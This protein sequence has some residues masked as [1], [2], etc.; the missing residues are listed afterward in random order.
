MVEETMLKKHFIKM[1]G[2]G[3]IALIMAIVMCFVTHSLSMLLFG[4]LV[5]AYIGATAASLWIDSKKGKVFSVYAICTGKE[6]LA[7]KA[8]TDFK[9]SIEY[10]FL[11][12]SDDDGEAVLYL[13]STNPLNYKEGLT[14]C[15]LFRETDDGELSIRNLIGSKEIN[16]NIKTFTV[17]AAQEEFT[18]D[19]E[20]EMA[21]EITP[22]PKITILDF[23]DAGKEE[24]IDIGDDF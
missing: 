8:S 15:L 18:E 20:G 1:A 10:Q 2:A 22:S 24:P 3:V 5:L 21:L 11:V 23:A 16:P 9:K 14:Y 13:A 17:D 19:R 6:T 12:A 4:A 7:R